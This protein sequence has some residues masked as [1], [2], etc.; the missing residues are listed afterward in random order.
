[1]TDFKVGD[2][3]TFDMKTFQPWQGGKGIVVA[4]PEYDRYGAGNGPYDVEVTEV[5]PE[6]GSVRV[7]HTTGFYPEWLK[8]VKPE[9]KFKSGGLGEGR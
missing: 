6:N 8:L 3:V 9:P 1:M 5:P 4:G 7:G 2:I